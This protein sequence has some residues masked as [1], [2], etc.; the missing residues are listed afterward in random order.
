M[1]Q[2][3]PHLHHVTKHSWSI[4]CLPSVHT[5]KKWPKRRWQRSSLT[6][7]VACAWLDSLVRML[8]AQCPFRWLADPT[9]QARRKASK[10]LHESLTHPID[11]GIVTKCDDMGN[12]AEPKDKQREELSIKHKNKNKNAFFWMNLQTTL[13]QIHSLAST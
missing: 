9:C 1:L 13:F 6:T 8:F 7:A 4:L 10:R 12:A 11:R 3:N 5:S 2:V